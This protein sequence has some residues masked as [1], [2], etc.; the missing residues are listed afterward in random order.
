M[1]D[2][3]AGQPAR[4]IRPDAAMARAAPRRWLNWADLLKRVFAIDVLICDT[5]GGSM[6]ILA[7]LPEGEASR[8]ILEHLGLPPRPP[9]R[10]HAPPG[11]LFG[12]D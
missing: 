7:V 11:R 6:R 10:A 9:S 2:L 8:T 3:F 4:C 5:C 1:R 12:D